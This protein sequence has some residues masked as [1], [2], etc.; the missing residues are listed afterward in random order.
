MLFRNIDNSD[1]KKET[2]RYLKSYRSYLVAKE[3]IRRSCI[4]QIKVEL[5][6]PYI[7]EGLEVEVRY[8]GKVITG[9]VVGYPKE[10]RDRFCLE[11]DELDVQEKEYSL[12]RSLHHSDFYRAKRK[13]FPFSA[14]VGLPRF[15]KEKLNSADASL[16]YDEF[17]F[18]FKYASEAFIESLKNTIITKKDV[19]KALA[20]ISP[21]KV[22]R[23]SS[24]PKERFANCEE[25]IREGLDWYDPVEFLYNGK[26]EVG[27]VGFFAIEG[28]KM[29]RVLSPVFKPPYYMK[30]VPK[31]NFLRWIHDNGLKKRLFD[32]LN[33][34]KARQ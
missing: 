28:Y 3:R 29:I 22:G 8:K 4:D 10:G 26:P 31:T 2:L 13:Y 18:E 21:M 14:I 25:A 5:L 19:D 27:L 6:M 12:G 1:I 24:L 17:K 33:E 7:Y 9:K 11:S 16:Q 20:I 30:Y 23:Y 32:E 34:L 15:V